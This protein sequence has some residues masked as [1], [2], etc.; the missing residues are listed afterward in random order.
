MDIPNTADDYEVQPQKNIT[1]EEQLRTEADE[2]FSEDMEEVSLP[3]SVQGVTEVPLSSGLH[4][5]RVRPIDP[6]ELSYGSVISV[7]QIEEAFNVSRKDYKEYNLARLVMRNFVEKHLPDVLGTRV[8]IKNAGDGLRILPPSE[9]A[10]E[11]R[12]RT[13]KAVSSMRK[14]ADVGTDTASLEDLTQEQ[15]AALH[16]ELAMSGIMRQA[17]IQ[18]MKKRRKLLQAPVEEHKPFLPENLSAEI[19]PIDDDTQENEA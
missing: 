5:A 17:H 10:E 6:R 4:E 15:R 9:V 11:M 16:G 1:E 19:K 2:E 18:G 3:P 8:F 12:R 13:M 14:S 7:E